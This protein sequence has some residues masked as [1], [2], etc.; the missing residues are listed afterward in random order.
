VTYQADQFDFDEPVG[1]LAV[2]WQLFDKENPRVYDLFKRYAFQA[3]KA[4][5][6]YCSG[7][8]IVERIRWEVAIQTLGEDF[9]VPNEFIP[10]MTRKFMT[11]FPAHEGFFETRK[12]EADEVYST[13]KDR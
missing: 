7:S 9:K 3:I 6:A 4:G 5:A 8:L 1:N 10:F 11:D 12:S 2:R 13:P